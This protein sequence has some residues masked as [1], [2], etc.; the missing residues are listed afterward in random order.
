MT[1]SQ[2]QAYH[3]TF[4]AAILWGTSFPVIKLTLTQEVSPYLLSFLRLLIAGSIGLVTLAFSHRLS[5]VPFA[6]LEIWGLAVLNALAFTLQHVGLQFTTPSK[7]A[8]LV[9]ANVVF[10]AMF[11][12]LFL[13]EKMTWAKVTGI[14]L[15]L[16]GVAVLTTGGVLNFFLLSEFAGDVLVFSAGVVWS[17]YVIL[18]KKTIDSGADPSALSIGLLALTTPLL[19]VPLIFDGPIVV[20]DST[21]L[22]GIV[23]LGLFCTLSAQVLWSLALRHL[24][25]TVASV[26]VLLEVLVSAIISI[27]LALD[28]FGPLLLVGGTLILTSVYFVS[29]PNMTMKEM[30]GNQSA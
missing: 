11:S 28:T 15:G 16:A 22:L 5:T 6:R 7:T 29:S 27:T 10:I 17:A 12:A 20:P 18:L 1:S 14:L 21:G 8:L 3:V 25:A 23:Y 9:N 19:L 2:S 30:R 24:T 4:L 13:S 26:L